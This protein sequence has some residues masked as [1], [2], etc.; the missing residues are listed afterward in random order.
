MLWQELLCADV[1]G[2]GCERMGCDGAL[3]VGLEGSRRVEEEGCRRLGMAT[4]SLRI[5]DREEVYSKRVFISFPTIV[6][7][8][9]VHCVLAW[10]LQWPG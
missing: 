9:S 3:A 5:Y 10:D 4:T 8:D 2:D 7:H 1:L 6:V